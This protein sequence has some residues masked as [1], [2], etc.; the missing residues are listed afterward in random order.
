MKVS[1]TRRFEFAYAHRLDG[2]DGAC[3][4]LHG[5]NAMCEITIVCDWEKFVERMKSAATHG[6][7]EDVCSACMVID[8]KRLKETVIARV[9]DEFDHKD[10]TK[11]IAD[12][13]KT[14]NMTRGNH[15][16][17]TAELM[18]WFIFDAATRFMT[19]GRRVEK[20]RVSETRDCWAE[21]SA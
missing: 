9:M 15:Y 17:P 10:I 2:H 4:N 18:A 16:V 19:D 14:A 6:T 12:N 3:A 8:F 11:K 1:V 7:Q 21:I 20:V 13:L 5:H